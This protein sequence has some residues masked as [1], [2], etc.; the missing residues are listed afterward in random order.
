MC[1]LVISACVCYNVDID[2]SFAFVL[3]SFDY[4]RKRRFG[5]GRKLAVRNMLGKS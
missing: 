2:D 3:L 4:Y 5:L 1:R